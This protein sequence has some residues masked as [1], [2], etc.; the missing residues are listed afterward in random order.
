MSALQA[1]APRAVCEGPGSEFVQAC[2][3]RFAALELASF[4]QFEPAL[5]TNSG[6]Y[7]IQA[8]LNVSL[9]GID[10]ETAR[11]LPGSWWMARTWSV[12]TQKPPAATSTSRLTWSTPGPPH[13]WPDPGLGANAGE[14]G[15]LA[16]ALN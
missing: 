10:S 9:P 14:S 5:G 7:L 8:R 6:Q 15:R 12:R 11:K 4:G 1:F 13:I 16:L 3:M 2:D